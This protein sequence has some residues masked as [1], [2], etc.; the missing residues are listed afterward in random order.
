MKL[1]F[2]I[3]ILL[4]LILLALA[5]NLFV[6]PRGSQ[7]A[8]AQFSFGLSQALVNAVDA[9][10]QATDRNAKAIEKVADQIAK[11]QLQAPAGL[12]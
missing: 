3:K 7:K 1:D 4:G 8:E 11:V 5:A 10:A 6:G 12:K 2:T 9:I